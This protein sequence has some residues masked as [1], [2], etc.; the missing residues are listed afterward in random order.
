MDIVFFSSATTNKRLNF[1]SLIPH[2]MDNIVVL[3]ENQLTHGNIKLHLILTIPVILFV[4]IIFRKIFRV[5]T[6]SPHQD[7]IHIILDTW[8]TFLST[9]FPYSIAN[10]P[11][12][13][14]S[15]TILLLS[16]ITSNLIT[17]I[18]FNYLIARP[19]QSGINSMK[20]LN[21][22]GLDIWVNEELKPTMDQWTEGLE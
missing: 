12:R 7:F 13:I 1:T 3:V 21:A 8:G 5:I 6:N 14:L 4:C 2:E 18:T 9:Y 11:E 15:L 22:L 20:E 16:I 19:V 10:R 17:A